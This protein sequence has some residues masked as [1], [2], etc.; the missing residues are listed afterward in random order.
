MSKS[1]KLKCISLFSG[2]GGLDI[3]LESA[4]FEV[5][6]ATDIDATCAESYQL[7]WPETPY[8]VGPIGQVSTEVLLE[9]AKLKPGEVD[10]L[11]GGP[12]CPAFSKSRFYLTEKPRALD[13]P[14]A[15]ETVGGYLRI[16]R[17]VRPKVFLLEN[18]R[19]L[20]YGVHR[21]ALDHI[22]DTARALGYDVSWRIVN[23]ADYGAPQIRERCL[24]MGSLYGPIST[25]EATHSKKGTSSLLGE[26]PRWVTAGD[27]LED[28]DTDE[29][30]SDEGHFAGGK[31][32]KELREIP[33]GEN[34]LF[35]TA[36]R[37]H[38]NPLFKWRSRYWSFLL[39]LSPNLPS[40][41]IQ[42]RRSN[43]M[44]PFHWR[45]RILRIEEIKRLQSFPDTYQL[46][47][48]VEKQWRQIGNAVPPILG[49]HFGIAIA[50]HL[51]KN[52]K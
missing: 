47:G 23:A 45:S 41:T 4:G 35:F 18:V 52:L 14:V 25:P 11:A 13:D 32:H 19:G 12:P 20:A 51:A 30:A 24:V 31:H 15:A 36:E 29:N 10:L 6:V 37:G 48:N 7:N 8:V 40:W 5:A 9:A 34:Y 28:L 38:P 22:L 46:A 49:Y 17:D 26:L 2:C 16:L 42:A 39:K 3:G 50:R 44:G 27:V 1:N 33:P 43:N 21:E